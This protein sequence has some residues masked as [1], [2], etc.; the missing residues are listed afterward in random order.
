M[1][2][3]ARTASTSER[4]KR[5]AAEREAG[6]AAGAAERAE[7]DLAAVQQAIV[8]V[9]GSHPGAGA[10][11]GG[12]AVYAPAPLFRHV[13]SS[14][15]RLTPAAWCWKQKPFWKS[16][17]TR[18][19]VMDGA[20]LKIYASEA[21]FLANNQDWRGGSLPNLAGF[22]VSKAPHGKHGPALLMRHSIDE[23]SH[24][25]F[26][27]Q[28]ESTRDEIYAACANVAEGREWSVSCVQ[29]EGVSLAAEPERG[30]SSWRIPMTDIQGWEEV[31]AQTDKVKFTGLTQNS[32]VD[33]AV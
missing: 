19:I 8:A 18:Y 30:G 17:E 32:Q 22:E 26:Q 4:E 5:Q 1:A 15:G 10:G 27:F 2:A 9:N 3:R 12:R 31:G 33:P 16:W 7:R 21:A 11:G 28:D 24:A 13:L 23:Q 14:G 25:F 20:A 29:G 6:A